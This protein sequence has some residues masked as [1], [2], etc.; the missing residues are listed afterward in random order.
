M[1][2]AP[3]S[4]TEKAVWITGSDHGR[5]RLTPDADLRQKRQQGST[6][7]IGQYMTE[8]RLIACVSSNERGKVNATL[9][10]IAQHLQRQGL[11][12]VGAVQH[13]TSCDDATACDMDVRV[14]PDGPRIRISQTLGSLSR[15]CRLDPVGLEQAVALTELGLAQG[16]DFLIV[17]KFGKH[18]AEG[19][20]FRSVISEAVMQGVPVIVGLG[21]LNR[22][23]F[24]DFAQGLAEDLPADPSAI[25]E[26][27]DS[28]R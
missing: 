3:R 6:S 8:Q 18:E 9:D 7:C 15:G 16:A 14:L 12:V 11:R 17:N 19:R 2:R 10:A 24:L 28:I 21:R 1:V 13:D 25:L 22:Q 23:A 20:G 26:W 4:G 5:N 27:C